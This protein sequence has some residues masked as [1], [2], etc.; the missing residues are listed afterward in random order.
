M[1]V[2]AAAED[3]LGEL[4]SRA[5]ALAAAS[6]GNLLECFAAVPDPRD[7]RGIRHSLPCVLALCTAGVLC[8]NASVEDVAAW[9]SAAPQ[10]VLAEAG[11]RRSA[12]GIRVAPH[13]DTVVRIFTGLGAQPP[14]RHA[15]A[16][17][18]A[19]AHAGPVAFPVAGP[20]WLPAVAV[21]GK[22]VRGAAGEDGLIPLARCESRAKVI[23]ITHGGCLDP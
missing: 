18:A 15:G 16:Y 13:P 19:R 10:Q 17:L 4:V 3:A 6:G 7:P 5:A 8:G 14:A 20:G 12:L 1:P 11:A 23:A 21:D 9:A 2:P 22:A